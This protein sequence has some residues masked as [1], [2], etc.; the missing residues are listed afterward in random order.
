MARLRPW[1]VCAL[2]GLVILIGCAPATP[3]AQP[4]APSPTTAPSAPP[5]AVPP[6]A[7]PTAVAPTAAPKPSPQPTAAPA[8]S[9]VPE[10]P[11]V[12]E[13]ER[14]A[15]EAFYRGKTVRI[16]VG[17]GP[18]GGFDQYARLLQR[19]M[20]RHI[21]GNP[22]MIV[23]NMPGAGSRVAAN[24]LYKT[25]APDGLTFGTFNEVQV[26]QQALAEQDIEFDARK[27]SWV[28][29]VAGS[30]PVCI[31]RTDTGVKT[32]K[33]LIDRSETVAF[34]GL[35][36]GSNP[37]DV[38]RLLKELVRANVRVVEGYDGT[39]AIATAIERGEIAGGCWTWETLSRNVESQLKSG[40]VIPIVQFA[41]R[42]HPDLKDV[43][44]AGDLVSDPQ[45]RAILVAYSGP[46]EISKPFAAP[47]GVPADRLRVLQKAF[48]D[49]LRDP[50]FQAEAQQ[51]KLDISAKSGEQVLQVVN[52]ILALDEQTAKRMAA[53]LAAGP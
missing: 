9:T 7:A 45:A 35:A 40:A 15:A 49:T 50:A 32:V 3:G 18:G 8:G 13:Q 12:S 24:T 30:T 47:P 5:T 21:P 4:P 19:H 28:G 52:Q 29:S 10:G 33:D 36:P 44:L 1:R 27:F 22:T 41:L 14:Q 2:L 53:V 39:A 17:Y 23:E 42:S 46:S 37:S 34:G 20:A 51:A 43:P 48:L 38:P 26:L 31:I 11:Q 6:T 25:T 16:V